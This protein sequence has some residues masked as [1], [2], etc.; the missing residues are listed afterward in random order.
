MA[1]LLTDRAQSQFDKLRST[2]RGW[3]R[4]EIRAG[5]CNGFEKV[6]GWSTEPS[7]DDIKIPTKSGA[8]LIDQI[9]HGLLANAIVDYV[10]DLS[11]SS[12]T[13]SIP[14]AGSSCGCGASFSL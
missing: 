2:G 9:S 3:P 10:D 12:F 8:V 13:I 14:E 4:I 5:G 11:G 7:E 6:F 1:V